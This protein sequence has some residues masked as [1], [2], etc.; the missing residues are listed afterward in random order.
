MI[1]LIK[2]IFIFFAGSFSVLLLV[3]V[4]SFFYLRHWGEQVQG[5]EAEVLYEIKKGATL[6]EVSGDLGNIRLVESSRLYKIW[7]RLFSQFSAFKAGTYKVRSPISPKE[8]SRMFIEGS[9]YHEVKYEILIPEGFTLSNVIEK[10]VNAGIGNREVFY[11][12]SKDKNFLSGLGIYAE[13]IEGFLYPATYFFYEAPTEAQVFKEM[14]STF[15][16]KLPPGI[17]MYA[18]SRGINLY[19]AIV[20]ASLIEAE[21][22]YDDERPLIAEVLWNRLVQNMQL[23]IDASVIY[24]IPNF[25][26]NLTKQNLLDVENKYNLRVHKGLPPTP[27]NSPTVASLKAI[28]NPSQEGYF[29]YVLSPG[30]QGRHFFSK[31]LSEHNAAV[32]RY[33][34]ANK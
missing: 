3:G 16:K 6:H 13:S 11:A 15:W 21:T 10:F 29:Y 12:L 18:A 24:G 25:N 1:K 7:V 2:S 8:L 5:V 20:L 28:F 23:G 9:T 32:A 26:G 30:A 17:E 4:F 22:M 27:I 19:Q 33:L 31:N 14:V 34:D